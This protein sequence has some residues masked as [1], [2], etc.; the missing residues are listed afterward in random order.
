[1]SA[2]GIFST[3]ITRAKAHSGLSAYSIREEWGN[4][5]ADDEYRQG[6]I[7]IEP[8]PEGYTV[9]EDYQGEHCDLVRHVYRI[10]ASKKIGKSKMNATTSVLDMVDN[11][12]TAM[13][14]TNDN[15]ETNHVLKGQMRFQ[16]IRIQTR[17]DSEYN[18]D[19]NIVTG[20]LKMSV[21]EFQDPASR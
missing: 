19:F 6:V 20:V 5:I 10:R 15:L 2:S 8:D 16:P 21:K 18:A 13:H 3:I 14:S 11:F 1:M 9:E 17:T 12:M 4:A 7:E